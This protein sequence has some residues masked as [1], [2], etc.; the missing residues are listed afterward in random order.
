MQFGD[1]PA[2]VLVADEAAETGRARL[3]HSSERALAES[4]VFRLQRE[5][6]VPS[7]G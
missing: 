5:L 3:F 2:Y 4:L 6:R 1:G 7:L